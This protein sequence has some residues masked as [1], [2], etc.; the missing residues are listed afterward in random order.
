MGGGGRGRGN[1]EGPVLMVWG[2]SF[3][4]SIYLLVYIFMVPT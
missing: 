2:S 4:I 1:K 3:F